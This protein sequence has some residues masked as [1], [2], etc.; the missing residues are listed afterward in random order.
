MN[1]RRKAKVDP[2]IT[3]TTAHGLDQIWQQGIAMTVLTLYGTVMTG[4]AFFVQ[5]RNDKLV[6]KLIDATKETAD[7]M[8]ELTGA[9]REVTRKN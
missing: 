9:I 1:R 8:N 6:D 3:Q 5:R 4:I 7:A 2:L